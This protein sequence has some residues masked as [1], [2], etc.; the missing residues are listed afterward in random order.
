MSEER[1][2][3]KEQLVPLLSR[4]MELSGARLA[5]E[6]VTS[7]ADVFEFL[8][9]HFVDYDLKAY[10]DIGEI[11]ESKFATQPPAE[12]DGT[13]KVEAGV[14]DGAAFGKVPLELALEVGQGRIMETCSKG[15]SPS[16]GTI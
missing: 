15:L 1:G 3:T 14:L 2:P 4:G 5:P 12:A 13:F 8:L 10:L 16:M 11:G 6:T 7:L 9:W